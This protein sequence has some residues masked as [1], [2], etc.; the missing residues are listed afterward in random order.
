[1]VQ[2]NSNLN[3]QQD[4]FFSF[5]HVHARAHTHSAVSAPFSLPN[6]LSA[7][8]FSQHFLRIASGDD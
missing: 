2:S 7:V 8:Q 5:T 1:M 3:K 6:T 4:I